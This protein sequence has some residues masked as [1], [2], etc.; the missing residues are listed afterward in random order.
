MG[1]D[2]KGWK[3]VNVKNEGQ[4]AGS[5]QIRQA[6]PQPIQLNQPSRQE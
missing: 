3:V 1:F 4:V 2:Y 5:L 6:S